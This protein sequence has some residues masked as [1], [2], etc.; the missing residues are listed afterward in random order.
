MG[1]QPMRSF[2]QVGKQQVGRV[3][4]AVVAQINDLVGQGMKMPVGSQQCSQYAVV[5]VQPTYM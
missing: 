3:A 5:R 1:N 2:V 4:K